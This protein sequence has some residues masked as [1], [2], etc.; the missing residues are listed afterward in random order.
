MRLR[1]GMREV[2]LVTVSAPLLSYLETAQGQEIFAET[3]FLTT[4]TNFFKKY[5]VEKL[6]TCT[7]ELWKVQEHD[8]EP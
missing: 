2:G 3:A 7:F 6:R 5:T 4:I 1:Y 8:H